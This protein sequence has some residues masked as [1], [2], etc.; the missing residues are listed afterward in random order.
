MS[1]TPSHF[2]ITHIAIL[3]PSYS[4]PVWKHPYIHSYL[5]QYSCHDVSELHNMDGVSITSNIFATGSVWFLLSRKSHSGYHRTSLFYSRSMYAFFPL[6]FNI[7]ASW[8]VHRGNRKT[9][10]SLNA[11]LS[12][13][14]TWI[15]LTLSF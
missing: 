9:G 5:R 14:L 4:M 15:P 12:L 2:L 8:M 13:C 10:S 11:L 7:S 1:Q 3:I 6:T